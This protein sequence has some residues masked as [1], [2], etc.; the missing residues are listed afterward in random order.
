MPGHTQGERNRENAESINR[1]SNYFLG[2]TRSLL[3]GGVF[4]EKKN[5]IV[6]TNG[7]SCAFSRSI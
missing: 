6:M 7:S 2:I 3:R 5:V 1:I 4:L